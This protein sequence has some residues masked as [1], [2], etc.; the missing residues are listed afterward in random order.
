MSITKKNKIIKIYLTL[1]SILKR[2][3]YPI[4][5]IYSVH[6]TFLTSTLH[7]K[8]DTTACSCHCDE[9][10]Q[11]PSHFE[12]RNRKGRLSPIRNFPYE[13]P[14]GGDLNTIPDSCSIS[15]TRCFFVWNI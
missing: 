5:K 14:V 15:S 2:Y 6:H 13:V 11:G 7:L 12:S 9:L 3:P 4:P 1:I 8:R 10:L